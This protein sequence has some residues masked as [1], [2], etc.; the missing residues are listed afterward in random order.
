MVN[1]RNISANDFKSNDYRYHTIK[2][3]EKN[4]FKSK[5][6]ALNYIKDNNIRSK[7]TET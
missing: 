3:F 6:E 7:R 1:I 4:F 5:K 2:P